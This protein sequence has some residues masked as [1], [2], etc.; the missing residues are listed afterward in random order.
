M[1]AD[2]ENMTGRGPYKETFTGT[3]FYP[4]DPRPEEV[5]IEDIAHALAFTCRFG[6]HCIKFYSVA[7]HSILIA[8]RAKNLYYSPRRCLHAL[9]HDAVEAYLGDITRPVKLCFP[10]IKEIELGIEAVVMAKFGLA[11]EK[12]QWLDRLDKRII[13]DERAQVLHPSGNHWVQD[14]LK[15]LGVKIKCWS[16]EHAEQLFM[17]TYERITKEMEK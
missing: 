5:L 17:E 8:R 12:P 13:V 7:E 4:L 14:S 16:P 11:P 1:K 10:Q 6:G 2:S 3:K 15:P 9:L